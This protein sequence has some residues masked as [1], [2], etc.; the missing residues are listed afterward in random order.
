MPSN[1]AV[2]G[3]FRVVKGLGSGVWDLVY[4]GGWVV[5]QLLTNRCI[6]GMGREAKGVECKFILFLSLFCSCCSVCLFCVR[7]VLTFESFVSW[8]SM[9]TCGCSEG[10]Y[11]FTFVRCS[12]CCV[13]C[14]SSSRALCP[15]LRSWQRLQSA[16]PRLVLR[17]RCA[18]RRRL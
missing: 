14:F 8:V 13:V 9:A 6:D 11:P 5:T 10:G 16:L 1:V 7:F 12:S 15:A 3:G 4:V 2:H 17:R 18:L